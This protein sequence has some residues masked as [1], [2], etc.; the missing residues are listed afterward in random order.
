MTP[1]ALHPLLFLT[2]FHT[3]DQISFIGRAGGATRR[4]CWGNDATDTVICY[5][6]GWHRKE[7]YC[8]VTNS[9]GNGKD[10]LSLAQ[11]GRRCERAHTQTGVIMKTLRCRYMGK[12][13]TGGA[14]A[15]TLA[16]RR[17]MVAHQ[18][19]VYMASMI[20]SQM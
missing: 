12:V 11:L 7:C 19:V 6:N 14:H 16:Q 20:V 15:G 8:M 18:Q 13:T 9:P 2:M 17:S 4:G 3:R 10:H 1:Q 5:S